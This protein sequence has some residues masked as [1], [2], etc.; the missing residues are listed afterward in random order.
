MPPLYVFFTLEN[1]TTANPQSHRPL[2]SPMP[3]LSFFPSSQP[4][5][6]Q[7]NACSLAGEKPSEE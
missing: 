1:S 3:W 2:P 6:G 5:L 4:T 7:G